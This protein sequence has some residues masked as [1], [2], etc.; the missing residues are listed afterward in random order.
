MADNKPTANEN[1]FA[2][3]QELLIN[4]EF[5]RSRLLKQ[6]FDPR[7]DLDDECG[8]P[9][10]NPS[11]QEYYDLYDRD[12][13]AA[14]VVEL[15]PK[16]CWQVQPTVYEEEEGDTQTEFEAA[17]ETMTRNLRAERSWHNDVTGSVLWEYLYRLDMV[18]GI[19]RYGVLLL[20][21][22]DVTGDDLSKPVQ[23]S[24]AL[25]LRFLRVFPEVLADI[26]QYEV[27]ASSP[28]LGMPT[29]YNLT[30]N[31]PREHLTGVGV[32]T[33]TRSVH[34]TRIIH[35]PSDDVVSSEF[36]GTERMRTVLNRIL[37]LRKVYGAASEGYWKA[38]FTLLTAET[39][40][41]LGGDVEINETKVK[42]MF[43]NMMNG[44]QRQ[45]VLSGMTLKSTAPAVV[46]PTPHVDKG[47]EAI[48][49]KLGCPVPVFKGYEIGEQASENNDTSWDERIKQRM[50]NRITPR[51]IVPFTDRLIG[52]GVLPQPQMYI[53]FWPD[54][55]AQTDAEKADTSVKVI[56]AIAQYVTSGA[57]VLMTPLDFFT[58]VLGWEQEEAEAVVMAS[59][60][61]LEDTDVGPSPM[62]GLTTGV[63]AMIELFKQAKAGAISED[64]LRSILML[65]FRLSEDQADEVIADGLTPAAIEA[66]DP[67]EPDPALPTPIKVKE[68]E[69]LV[70]PVD[71]VGEPG[72]TA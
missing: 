63:M 12:P 57:N 23:V 68:G 72:E 37:D 65:F 17:W 6:L 10:Q 36:I 54:L 8:Y 61:A 4:M 70:N 21:F 51:I 31:D 44:L 32:S 24:K 64:Q 1:Q 13:I 9:K 30:F 62:I 41:S 52:F 39:H 49:I 7:R 27:D 45:G 15:F 42:E 56:M 53:V 18:S 25:R 5:S 48:C 46:D 11:P 59:V 58:R 69:T 66:A 16:E 14:R 43:E 33:S 34:W 26:T 55:S 50:N 3:L 19:G 38:C 20:G 22:N 60:D 71:I 40:P 47:I 2:K 29:M 35:V 67:T 28:R